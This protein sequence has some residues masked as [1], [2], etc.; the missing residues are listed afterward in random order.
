MV[1]VGRWMVLVFRLFMGLGA[2]PLW[3]LVQLSNARL[4]LGARHG[5]GAFLGHMAIYGWFLRLGP[6][7]AWVRFS[8]RYWAHLVR[9]WCKH[10]LRFWFGLALLQ[11]C[12]ARA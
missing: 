2:I 11:L 1:V 6:F 7:A 5:V 8:Q 3:S 4:D 9:T 12:A 10:R